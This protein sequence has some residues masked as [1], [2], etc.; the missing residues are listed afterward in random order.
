MD[1]NENGKQESKTM[2]GFCE[3]HSKGDT[4]YERRSYD[5]GIDFEYIENI[6]FCPICGRELEE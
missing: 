2:C 4:L 6:K 1:D 3:D 5:G